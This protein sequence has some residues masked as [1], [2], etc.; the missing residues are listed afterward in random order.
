[1]GPVKEVDSQS[2]RWTERRGFVEV[3]RNS[4]LVLD[5]ASVEA[6]V[7]VAPT[8]IEIS[9]WAERPGVEQGMYAVAR[10]AYPDVPGE[11]DA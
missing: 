6:P 2:L 9:T 11:E 7:V 4:R 10:E 5:L 8:G 3:G 1:M